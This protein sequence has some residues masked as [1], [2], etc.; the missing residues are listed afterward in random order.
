MEFAGARGCMG[1]L[2]AAALIRA[3]F[4]ICLPFRISNTSLY[5]IMIMAT[6]CPFLTCLYAM[7]RVPLRRQSR[8]RGVARVHWGFGRPPRMSTSAERLD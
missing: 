8:R 6:H 1:E 7:R 5:A 3:V 4:S 2:L